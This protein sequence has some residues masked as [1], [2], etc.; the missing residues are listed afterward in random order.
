MEFMRYKVSDVGRFQQVAKHL[1]G[2]L[3]AAGIEGLNL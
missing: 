3:V 1:R 2:G